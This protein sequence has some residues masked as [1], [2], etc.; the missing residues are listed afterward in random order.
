MSEPLGFGL[1]GTGLVAPFHANSICASKGG[2]LVGVCDVNRERADKLAGTYSARA[3]YDMGDMLKNPEI[4]VVCELT[5]NHLHHDAV[6]QCARAGKH[7]IVE[8]P[9][10][11]SL[12][13]TDAMVDACAQA[14]LKFACTV[15]WRVR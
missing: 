2:R 8:K 1:V 3:Y 12:K 4:H 9:P 11:M 14:G 10:A 13:E 7:V 15:Q 5:P 6:I